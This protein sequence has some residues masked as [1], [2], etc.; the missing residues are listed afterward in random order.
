MC[1]VSVSVMERD[2]MFSPREEDAPTGQKLD[3]G[4]ATM[5]IP[6]F[7]SARI[8]VQNIKTRYKIISTSTTLNLLFV[9][10]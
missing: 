4:K 6:N 3:F 9:I 5:T 8:T 7:S 2:R 10:F 1:N